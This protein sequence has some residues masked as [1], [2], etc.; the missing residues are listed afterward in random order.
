MIRQGQALG[1]IR[2]DLPD[3]L[4]FGWLQALDRASDDW[5]LT[6]W[7]HLTPESLARYSDLTIE[8]MRRAVAPM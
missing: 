5:L 4:L 1:V 6:Q 7:Q 3:E 2:T 8:A